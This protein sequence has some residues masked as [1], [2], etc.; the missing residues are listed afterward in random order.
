M[1]R[2]GMRVRVTSP[3][4]VG[5]LLGFLASEPSTTVQRVSSDELEVSLLGSYDVDAMRM[6]LYL[7]LRAWEAGRRASG[8]EAEIVD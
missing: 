3:E 8:A 2:A 6:E 7:R 1:I 5:D 4:L